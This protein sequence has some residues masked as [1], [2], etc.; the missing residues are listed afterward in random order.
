MDNGQGQIQKMD[1]NELIQDID[2]LSLEE[3]AQLVEHLLKSSTLTV[4]MGD[5]NVVS[6]SSFSFQINGDVN[7]IAEQLGRLQPEAV[8]NIL[9]AIALRINQP[10]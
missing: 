5:E 1:L 6:N 2:K 8:E 7:K 10:H 3:R 4:V 9:K